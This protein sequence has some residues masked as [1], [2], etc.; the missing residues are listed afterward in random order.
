[1]E[2]YFLE[3]SALFKGGRGKDKYL[4]QALKCLPPPH[5]AFWSLLA[6]NRNYK[7]EKKI[8]NRLVFLHN[9]LKLLFC[10][11]K[12]LFL[13]KINGVFF[14]NIFIILIQSGQNQSINNRAKSAHSSSNIWND[15][16]VIEA[17]TNLH[18]VEKKL[19]RKTTSNLCRLRRSDGCNIPDK[20]KSNEIVP[21]E[22][23]FQL[24]LVT[25]QL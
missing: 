3:A 13:K 16:L 19:S 6:S 14:K 12:L 23:R 15:A 25:I 5:Q 18:K 4:T 1:M 10:F 20:I 2:F 17:L 9:I 8:V 21:I 24:K 11:L 7:L 22:C